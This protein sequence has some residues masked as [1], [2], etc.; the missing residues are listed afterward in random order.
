MPLMRA[1]PPDGF[2]Q[3]E[4]GLIPEEWEA[5]ELGDICQHRRELVEPQQNGSTLGL[6]T[7]TLGTLKSNA[8]EAT[9]KSEVPKAVSMGAMCCMANCAPIWTK[10]F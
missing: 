1:A 4:I 3:T 8:T 9:P 2:K 5:C 10:P 6:S 7:L